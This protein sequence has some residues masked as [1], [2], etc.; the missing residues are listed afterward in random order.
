MIDSSGDLWLPI[1]QHPDV[2]RADNPN[3]ALSRDQAY[4]AAR[5][6]RVRCI[7]LS[8]RRLLVHRRLLDDL[9]ASGKP[10]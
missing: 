3:G 10:Q 6:G 5:S 9:A 7:W 2:R 8:R 1:D 4:A